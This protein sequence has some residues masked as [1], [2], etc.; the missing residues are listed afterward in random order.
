MPSVTLPLDLSGYTVSCIAW[1]LK[2][3]L[4]H[5]PTCSPTPIQASSMHFSTFPRRVAAARRRG[6]GWHMS[7]LGSLPHTTVTATF[8]LVALLVPWCMLV[9]FLTM[10]ASRCTRLY[11]PAAL[12]IFCACLPGVPPAPVPSAHAWVRQAPR[13][14]LSRFLTRLSRARYAFAPTRV[15]ASFPRWA[16]GTS[17]CGRTFC[18][19]GNPHRSQAGSTPSS[20]LR[21]PSPRAHWT[22]PTVAC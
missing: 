17:F 15:L 4:P 1:Q 7:R 22:R 12:R 16:C 18:A 8:S 19:P 2:R 6:G 5:T 20:A 13:S 21:R 9:S 11:S 10:V 14:A 3:S